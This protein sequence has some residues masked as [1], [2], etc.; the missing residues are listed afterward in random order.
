MKNKY[1][2]IGLFIMGISLIISLYYNKEILDDFNQ[3]KAEHD[4]AIIHYQDSLHKLNVQYLITKNK[5][6]QGEIEIMIK[7][8]EM[9]TLKRRYGKK[10]SSVD[11]ISPDSSRSYISDRYRLETT[12]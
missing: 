12:P 2:I 3:L 7:K 5:L 10:I 8:A 11:H 1:L 6:E 9:E 4:Q